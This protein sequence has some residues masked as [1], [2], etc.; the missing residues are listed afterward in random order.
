MTLRATIVM[1]HYVRRLAATRFPRLTALDLDAFRQQLA[2][3][4]KHYTPV[5]A[6][7]L[8]S[9]VRGE[10]E[11]PPRSIVLT[12]DDGYAEHYRDV[13]PLLVAARMPGVFFPA[14]SSLL[15]RRVLD[16]N[17][18]QFV[19]AAAETAD[20]V[21]EAIDSVVEREGGRDDV[22]PVTDYR[23]EGWKPVR[24][25]TPAAS[26]VN[27]ML[28]SALPA[29][30]RAS[31]LDS[32]FAAFVS[33]DEQAFADELYFTTDHARALAAAGMTVGCHA[34]RHITLTS[35]SRDGQAAEFDFN[36]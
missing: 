34:D 30:L 8:V 20:V 6:L 12:F 33:T 1:Y 4:V 31:V 27:H 19:L 35:L 9:A 7:D 26:Y 2:Y 24:F 16:V 25:D 32:L 23:T 22:K 10:T 29:D 21:A 18:I 11:L 3:I 36:F 17:K 13:L 15:D 14:A 28:Q 5:S